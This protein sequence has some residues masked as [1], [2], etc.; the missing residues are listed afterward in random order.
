MCYTCTRPT[1]CAYYLY[2]C[3]YYLIRNITT[4]AFPPLRYSISINIIIPLHIILLLFFLYFSLSF[5]LSWRWYLRYNIISVPP[6]EILFARKSLSHSVPQSPKNPSS[7][8]TIAAAAAAAAAD[9]QYN[10]ILFRR[11][12]S[13]FGWYA[14]S[15]YT[16]VYRSVYRGF[17][18]RKAQVV[19]S[20]NLTRARLLPCKWSVATWVAAA[21]RPWRSSN[22]S[23]RNPK[24]AAYSNQS[25]GLGPI[26]SSTSL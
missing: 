6:A 7:R 11:P 3:V 20:Y 1:M 10:T 5:S 26:I 15:C 16:Q 18:K 25:S 21:T 22:A 17:T 9:I 13:R 8:T 4:Y 14:R 19:T 23:I 2:Y 24:T 12:D